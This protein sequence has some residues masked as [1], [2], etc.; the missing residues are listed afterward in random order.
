VRLLL[1]QTLTNCHVTAVSNL[2]PS[3]GSRGKNSLSINFRHN[4]FIFK[5]LKQAYLRYQDQKKIFYLFSIESP[6][7]MASCHHQFFPVTD[8]ESHD[9]YNYYCCAATFLVKPLSHEMIFIATYRVTIYSAQK[10]LNFSK[11]K[12]NKYYNNHYPQNQDRKRKKG[13][14][15]CFLCN[16]QDKDS[17]EITSTVH[18]NAEMSLTIIL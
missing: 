9:H 12:L 1:I 4:Y 2:V 16:I 5:I 6:E 10:I 3:T 8:R 17:K 11:D 18:K 15:F 13:M 7:K 14:V